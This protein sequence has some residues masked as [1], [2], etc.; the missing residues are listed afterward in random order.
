MNAHLNDK[1]FSFA[2]FKTL[3]KPYINGI[4]VHAYVYDFLSLGLML[5]AW[6]IHVFISSFHWL[7]SIV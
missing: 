3:H 6:L 2:S 1:S 4:I 5:V 7:Y